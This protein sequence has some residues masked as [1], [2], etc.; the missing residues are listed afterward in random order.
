MKTT[1]SWNWLVPR[2]VS[3]FVRSSLSG[4]AARSRPCLAVERLED[5][6]VLSAASS[7]VGIGPP[8]SSGGD[9]QI[10]IGLLRG[11]LTVTQDE[12]QLLKVL[13]N[14]SPT[15][16]KGAHSDFQIVKVLDK[17]SPMLFQLGDTL[18]KIG[19]DL[20]K[21]ELT[22]QKLMAAE[23]KIEYL[24][25]KLTDVIITSVDAQTQ[26]AVLP[27]VDS[28]FADASSLV[29]GLLGVQ[30]AADAPSESLS[31]NFTKIAVEY[32]EMQELTIKGELDFIKGQSPGLTIDDFEVKIENVFQKANDA[33]IKLG[34]ATSD[35]LLPAVQD[36]ETG[37]L[38]LLGSLSGGG[39]FQGGVV[40]PATDDVIT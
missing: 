36:F 4:K 38:N 20:I 12:F 16:N 1:H 31:L 14:A 21:G 23:A 34:P 29:Q 26:G 18:V 10:L 30:A 9:T 25:I 2:F 11:G 39:D 3:R 37:V 35:A 6:Q 8:L 27:I 7:G 32:K 24:K 5:R 17:A 22:G 40:A 13:G 15:E 19:D 28:L 33:I